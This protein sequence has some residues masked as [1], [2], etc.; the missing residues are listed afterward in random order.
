MHQLERRGTYL[1]WAWCWYPGPRAD[2]A[3][4]STATEHWE[5]TGSQSLTLTWPGYQHYSK[6]SSRSNM[7]SLSLL[8]S[9][10][11]FP[12]QSIQSLQHPLVDQHWKAMI[13]AFDCR[14]GWGQIRKCY[15]NVNFFQES[16]RF[17]CTIQYVI[18]FSIKYFFSQQ[19]S[20][21]QYL[22]SY[23]SNFEELLS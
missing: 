13:F 20:G 23:E 21:H 15:R 22:K 10:L 2:P 1:G 6:P 14:Q 19:Q 18:Y 5:D 3:L 4:I 11:W 17:S 12:H 8:C 16:T 9:L 7:R